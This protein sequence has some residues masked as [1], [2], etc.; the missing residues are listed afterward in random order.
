MITREEHLRV[1]ARVAAVTQELTDA[2]SE[3]EVAVAALNRTMGIDVNAPTRVE[4][5]RRAPGVD[6]PLQG[7]LRLAVANRPEIP[8]MVRGIAVAERDVKVVRADFL[9]TV[10]VQAGYSNV[11]GTHIQN[12]NVAAGG[13]FVTQDL[14]D[15][16]RRRGQLRAAEAGVRSAIAQAQQV[17]DG[18][19]YEVNV[20]FHGVEDARERIRAARATFEQAGE[21]LRLVTSRFRAGDATPAE[22]MEARASETAAEQTYNAALYIYQRTLIRLEYAVGA[23]LPTAGEEASPPT[24]ESAPTPPAPPSDRT[25][26]PFRPSMPPGGLP[27][28]PPPRDFGGPAPVGPPPLP[29][30][31]APGR[32]GRRPCSGPRPS[33]DRRMRP[34]R[35]TG[36]GPDPG[37]A[38]PRSGP[39]AWGG[40]GSRVRA[41]TIATTMTS[42]RTWKAD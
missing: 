35:R 5:R 20:A 22:L 16:G 9:P 21:Y 41:S 38:Q 37:Y 17:C 28:L 25:P 2:R 8:V 4:G 7:A 15:G 1:E 42:A 33:P 3:E 32:P 13:I 23:R 30:T 39:G 26:S 10:S 40:S 18:I 27:G 11:T 24:S 34:T 36:S 19:A 12:S 31:P 14:Y 29:T 6:L